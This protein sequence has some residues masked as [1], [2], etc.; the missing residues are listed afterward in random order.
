VL[1]F[2]ATWPLLILFL[3]I[4]ASI[5][6][7]MQPNVGLYLAAALLPFYFQHKELHL[8]DLSLSIPPATAVVLVSLPAIVGCLKQ[9]LRQ[10]RASTLIWTLQPLDWFGIGWLGISLLTMFNVWHWPGYRAGILELVIVPLLLYSMVRLFATDQHPQTFTAMALLAG[11]ILIATIGLAGWAAGSGTTADS[12]RR[13][14]GPYFSPNHAA[15]YLERSLFLG[16]GFRLFWKSNN[17]TGIRNWPKQMEFYLLVSI[18]GIG[19]ALLL[20]ASRGALILGMPIGLG[21]FT[22]LAFSARTDPPHKHGQASTEDSGRRWAGL[23]VAGLILA[24]VSSPSSSGHG[25]A[26]RQPSSSASASGKLRW[27]YGN[28]FRHSALDRAVS[29]GDSQNTSQSAVHWTPIC[30][31]PTASGSK[32]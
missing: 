4:M 5:L 31:I 23:A 6:I 16:L 26:T 1:Y 21:L 32:A 17:G 29:I 12:V 14:V 2:F 28:H 11:G 15:L 8:V 10:Y 9:N 13:L 22:W 27:R 24:V 20:T 19:A 7:V 25:S 18:V 30:A 3:M